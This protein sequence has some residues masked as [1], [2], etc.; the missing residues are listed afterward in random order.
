M[1]GRSARG[2]A[3]WGRGPPGGC[4]LRVRRDGARRHGGRG[5]ALAGLALL[6]AIAVTVPVEGSLGQPGLT[7]AMV[8]VVLLILIGALGDMLAIAVAAADEPA[9]HSMAARRRVGAKGAL[10]LKRRADRVAS[11]SGDIVGDVAGTVSGA[12][13]AAWSFSAAHAHGWPPTEA[14][15]LAVAVVAALTVGAKGTLKGIALEHSH[16]VLQAA[17]YVAHVASAPLGALRARRR[18]GLRRR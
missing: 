9:L 15:A 13:G 6:V 4:D 14:A 7:A 5:A 18:A 8:A 11:I 1:P 17:G 3:D 12:I 10:A 2:V 16:A